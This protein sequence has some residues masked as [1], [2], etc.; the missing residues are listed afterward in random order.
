MP[1]MH[2]A[3]VYELE[4]H[5]AMGFNFIRKHIKASVRV[6]ACA[7]VRVRARAGA[8]VRVRASAWGGGLC[9]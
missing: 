5:K 6:C 9:V 7:C 1:C 2:T 4:S 3:D 8:C